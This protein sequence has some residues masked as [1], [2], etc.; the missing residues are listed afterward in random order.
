MDLFRGKPQTPE[1]SSGRVALPVISPQKPAVA[2]NQEPQALFAAGRDEGDQS[3]ALVAVSEG[4]MKRKGKKG[5]DLVP[6]EDKPVDFP[7]WTRCM[8]MNHNIYYYNTHTGE[9]TWLA[10]CSICYKHADKWCQDCGVSYCDKHFAKKHNPTAAPD[11][12]TTGSPSPP[13]HRWSAKEM[14][15]KKEVQTYEDS[16]VTKCIECCVKKATKMCLECWDP[17]CVQCFGIVHHVGSLR[18]HPSAL[19][20]EVVAGWRCVRTEPAAEGGAEENEGDGAEEAQSK[21]DRY[22]VHGASKE[23]T[24]EKPVE[25]MNPLER[26]LLKNFKAHQQAADKY[27]A[28]IEQLQFE[29]EKA[30]YERDQL[31][32]EKVQRL[33]NKP[34]DEEELG[35]PLNAVKGGDAYMDMLMHPSNRKRGEGRSNYIKSLL[36]AP[37]PA[38]NK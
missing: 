11:G 20:D 29:L 6:H 28:E 31:L 5:G 14:P 18:F 36:E 9:S 21:P 30:R 7:F 4:S 1:T 16:L 3:Q 12:T 26:T 15:A 19:Y 33:K 34:S 13:R 32:V 22:Y 2:G 8:D 17:Y 25:L 10:P 38:K 27:V 24:Y 35:K 23:T 37:M